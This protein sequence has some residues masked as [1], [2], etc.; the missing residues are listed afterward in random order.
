MPNWGSDTGAY[1]GDV[2]T[3]EEGTDGP[4]VCW[5]CEGW[6]NGG[7]RIGVQYFDITSPRT[8]GSL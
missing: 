5:D 4:E 6:L 3:M 7:D 1:S 2:T 8:P